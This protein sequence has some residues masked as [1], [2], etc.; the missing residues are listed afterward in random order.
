M[1]G[2]PRTLLKAL[3]VAGAAVL[4]AAGCGGGGDA[5]SGGEYNLGI[6]A[7]LSGA[8]SSYGKTLQQGIQGYVDEVNAAGGIN[9]HKI[10]LT[11]LDNGGEQARAAANATQLATASKVNAMFGN[12]LSSNCSA[13]QPVAERYEVPM[14]CISVAEPNPYVFS[15]GPDNTRAA[16]AMFD[17]AKKVTEK[18]GPKAALVY[19]NTLTNEALAKSMK[20]QAGGAG[21]ELATAQE[22]DLMASDVSAQVTKVVETEPDVVLVTTTGPGMLSVLKGVRAAGVQAPFVWLDGTGNFASLVSSKDEGV[23]AMNVY[24][25]VDPAGT[26]SGVK[27]YIGAVEPAIQDAATAKGL[28]DGELVIGY[29][30]ARAFGEALKSCGHPCS[31][32]QLKTHLDQTRLSVPGVVDDYGFTP[33]D[34]YP[35]KNWYLYHAV[36]TKTTLTETLTASPAA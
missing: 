27:E 13:A 12:V 9:G 6:N 3:A 8:A 16:S 36:G 31:G 15:I 29:L 7:E 25:L 32:E 5:G 21:V 11:S 2:A 28:N 14:G 19:L 10:K 4:A 20:E 30:A 26:E 34:R 22:V 18:D 35:F 24:A 1:P 33:E 17:A 23:Y